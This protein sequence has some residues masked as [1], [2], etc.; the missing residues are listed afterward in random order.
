MFRLDG[1]VVLVFGGGSKGGALNNGLSACLA[2]ASAGA[3]VVLADASDEAVAGALG[4]FEGSGFAQNEAV[5]GVRADVISEEDVA[6]AVATAVERFGRI[7]TLHNNVGIARTGGPLEMDLEEWD[8]VLRV[9]LT[10]AFL[11][12]KHALP[13]LLARERSSI[14]NIASVAGL[15]YIGYNYPSYSA[16]K[17][18]LI[19]LTQNIALEYASRGLRANAIAPGY[20]RTPMIFE[21]ISENYPSA[22][23]MVRA[24]NALSPTGVMG[25]SSDVAS[26]AVFLASDEARYVNGTC[27]VVDGGLVSRATA[28]A[29]EH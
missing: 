5:V 12:A 17:A 26:A 25:E 14:V 15:R 6:R 2:Y 16:T 23:E 19:G 3:R 10:S 13:H 29:R 4:R 11:T 9:N 21:Q 20:I 22:E 28:P 7:D 27:L 24:R 8:T 1:K 18:G